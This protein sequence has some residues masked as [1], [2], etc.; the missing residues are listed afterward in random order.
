ME[1]YFILSVHL[2]EVVR[3][4]LPGELSTFNCSTSFAKTKVL[5][6]VPTLTLKLFSLPFLIHLQAVAIPI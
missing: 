6:C 2:L 4:P 3:A 1:I 5:I